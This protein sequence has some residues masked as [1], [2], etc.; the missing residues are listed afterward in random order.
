MLS[1]LDR[2]VCWFL[3]EKLN[4]TLRVAFD[5]RWWFL[6]IFRRRTHSLLFNSW[7]VTLPLPAN[8]WCC[9]LS[10]SSHVPRCYST[11]HFCARVSGTPSKAT[12]RLM[13]D[14]LR[15]GNIFKIGERNVRLVTG[16]QGQSTLTLEWKR[17]TEPRQFVE[18]QSSCFAWFR[19]VFSRHA[20]IDAHP[21]HLLT[22][23]YT[24]I[25]L[26][27]RNNRF[28]NIQQIPQNEVLGVG[29]PAFLAKVGR[30]CMSIVLLLLHW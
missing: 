17:E 10:F 7:T 13:L 6:S 15:A 2:P 8:D 1:T 14:T 3:L 12:G 9:W 25:E 5:F 18:R 28:V 4:C 21:S 22:C 29:L 20:F 24:M 30:P 23:R 19:T 26:Y 16:F 27:S 11:W